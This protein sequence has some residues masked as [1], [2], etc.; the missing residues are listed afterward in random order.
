MAELEAEAR[1]NYR[2]QLFLAEDL[3]SYQLDAAGVLQRL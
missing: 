3:A 2:G 1:L